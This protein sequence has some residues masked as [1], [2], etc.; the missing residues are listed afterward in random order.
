MDPQTLTQP[1]PAAALAQPALAQPAAAA[2]ATAAPPAGADTWRLGNCPGC[3]LL[4]FGGDFHLPLVTPCVCRAAEAQPEAESAETPVAEPQ[5]PASGAPAL[6]LAPALAPRWL[7]RIIRSGHRAAA[8]SAR[9]RGVAQTRTCSVYPCRASCSIN[10]IRCPARQSPRPH[11]HEPSPAA[12]SRTRCSACDSQEDPPIEE[13][14][15]LFGFRIPDS[16]FH[17]DPAK[18]AH[19]PRLCSPAPRRHARLI[20]GAVE[21][22]HSLTRLCFCRGS[23]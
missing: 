8:E 16:L 21:A 1:N 10:R 9:G 4:P 14:A 12:R 23:E 22:A 18:G 6:P 11:S 20:E 15:N 19:P 17:G 7:R 5:E 2:P 13:R 3:A